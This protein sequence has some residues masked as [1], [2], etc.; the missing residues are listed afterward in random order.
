MTNDKN[1]VTLLN[2]RTIDI[3]NINNCDVDAAVSYTNKLIVDKY[4][5]GV[6]DII[7][8]A[9]ANSAHIG[10][11]EYRVA[12]AAE[13]VSVFNELCCDYDGTPD[14][15]DGD[16]HFLLYSSED[17]DDI[18]NRCDSEVTSLIKMVDKISSIELTEVKN[19]LH[20][21]VAN[22]KDG[23][24]EYWNR[25]VAVAAAPDDIEFNTSC[26]LYTII[27]GVCDSFG[28]Y[29][30]DDDG[31]GICEVYDGVLDICA[32]LTDNEQLSIDGVRKTFYDKGFDIDDI[33]EC[34]IGTY[35][36]IDEQGDLEYLNYDLCEPFLDCLSCTLRS[37]TAFKDILS[38]IEGRFY[39]F[40]GHDIKP[41]E[42]PSYAYDNS[43]GFIKMILECIDDTN[44]A[45]KRYG[46]RQL[47]RQ[48]ILIK[49]MHIA[50]LVDDLDY[51]KAYE[52]HRLRLYRYN[53]AA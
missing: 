6:I 42:Q 10:D 41:D 3:L 29:V 40:F 50:H 8:R 51:D 1:L 38:R 13:V 30:N 5:I 17:D 12:L 34:C 44:T 20:Y 52:A 35:P 11:S 33:V 4:G 31:E 46:F 45:L 24:Y 32:E 19:R 49:S 48:F 9:I 14:G 21:I 28:A 23:I 22:H 27:D 15:A 47:D 39:D 36:C 7:K 16:V 26:K 25:A 37:Y 53:L 43:V 18:D 2:S